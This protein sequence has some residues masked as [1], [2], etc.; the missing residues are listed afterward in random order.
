[1]NRRSFVGTLELGLFAAPLAAA[2][3]LAK[4]V[5]KIGYVGAGTSEAGPGQLR[6]S[7]LQGLHDLGYVE[8]RDFVMEH[9]LAEGHPDRLPALAADLVRAQVDVIRHGRHTGDV[10]GNAGDPDHP[11]RFWERR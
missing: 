3:Q 4:R 6:K 9:R 11:D 7:F 8:G 2:P 5:Y 1:M 10:C